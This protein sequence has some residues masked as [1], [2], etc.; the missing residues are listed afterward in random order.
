[1]SGDSGLSQF[2]HVAEGHKELS[3]FTGQ[4]RSGNERCLQCGWVGVIGVVNQKDIIFKGYFLKPSFDAGKNAQSFHNMF[5]GFIEAQTDRC[6]SQCVFYIVDTRYPQADWPNVALTG[7]V[8]THSFNSAIFDIDASN[9]VSF[10]QTEGD[11]FLVKS[12]GVL[13][14]HIIIS[15]QYDLR[16]G[17]KLVHQFCFGFRNTV[18]IAQPFK[19]GHSHV[20]N[21][22]YVGI[23]NFS[24]TGDFTSPVHA[25]FKHR[26]L[27]VFLQF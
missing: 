25:H 20:Q 4:C 15:V 22:A 16:L 5:R 9:P 3:V 21:H 1:M 14:Q 17:R 10:L 6:G 7:Q 18:H 19:M 23:C 13:H 26:S 24:Q 2:Q 27:M 11:K 8:K 12:S